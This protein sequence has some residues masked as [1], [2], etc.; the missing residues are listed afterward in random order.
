M[1]IHWCEVHWRRI[2]VNGGEHFFFLSDLLTQIR[3][4]TLLFSPAFEKQIF[5]FSPFLTMEVFFLISSKISLASVQ[6]EDIR[7]HLFL[8]L[9]LLD[10]RKKSAHYS[11]SSLS[12]AQKSFFSSLSLC[13]KGRK[14]C[15]LFTL[16][17]LKVGPMKRLKFVSAGFV[18]CH[19]F[20]VQS[21]TRMNLRQWAIVKLNCSLTG[22]S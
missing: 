15:D 10:V 9:D 11:S 16:V 5:G 19:F 18:G 21:H 4:E 14:L 8:R 7:P 22:Q 1:Y 12:E 13:W 3:E 17:F 2:K 20:R 6:E